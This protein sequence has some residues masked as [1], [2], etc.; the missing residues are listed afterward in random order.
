MHIVDVIFAQ[1]QGAFYN[2]DQ[3]AV[4]K[5][6][7][8][9]GFF[10]T[11]QPL[12]SGFSQI[13]TPAPVLAIGLVLNNGLVS[14][15][16]MMTVQYAAAGGREPLLDSVALQARLEAELVPSLIG[17][18]LSGFRTA[19]EL[20]LAG[21]TDRA[22]LPNSAKYGLSQALLTAVAASKGC[23]PAEVIS[24][25]YGFPLQHR[26]VPIFCQSGEDR[27]TNVDKMILRRADAMPHGLI[28]NLALI[29][30]E[31]TALA[32]Y[33]R[34]V[35]NRIH[36]HGKPDYRP[37]LH[38]D[39]YGG[40][41]QIFDNDVDRIV[42]LLCSLEALAEPFRLRVESPADF[43]SGRDQI[44]GLAQIRH[45]L[46]ERGSRV[47]IIADEW[48]NTLADVDAFVAAGAADLIQL[49]MPD[50]GSLDDT[51]RGIELCRKGGI[52]V[53]LGGS[54]TETDL[55]A[56]ISVHVAVAAQ[57]DLMLAKPGMGVD[58]A[59]SIVANEQSRLVTILRRRAERTAT[60]LSGAALKESREACQQRN[61]DTNK[62][63]SMGA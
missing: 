50:M 22:A 42:S 16:D 47:Q 28:N 18:N 19:M 34:W 32:D 39:V 55:S 11:T 24:V 57:V 17:L 44:T 52:G 7:A 26:P 51:L 46:R 1:G 43:G 23:T 36:L 59:Y 48:C 60:G 9:D 63:S 5:G 33:V 20:S 30:N 41:G 4:R 35:R 12:T 31:G 40:I 56:R 6:A 38:F 49:K 54:C 15:G 10:Y 3:V 25:E 13:R 21:L 27:C 58:E 62:L 37:Y 61:P 53:Y 2:D 29:G 8:R 45:S 14:W